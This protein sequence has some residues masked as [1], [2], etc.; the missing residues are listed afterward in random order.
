MKKSYIFLILFSIGFH[1]TSFSQLLIPPPK[2]PS[3][4][5]WA[6]VLEKGYG[7]CEP[8]LDFTESIP[9]KNVRRM[10]ADLILPNGNIVYASSDAI[11]GVGFVV[12][13]Y[14]G[15]TGKLIW[16][17]NVIE[18]NNARFLTYYTGPNTLE[19]KN[20]KILLFGYETVGFSNFKYCKIMIDANTG[21]FEKDSGGSNPFQFSGLGIKTIRLDQNYQLL[22][23][24]DSL[25]LNGKG[26]YVFKFK[27][28]SVSKS[29]ILKTF[30]TPPAPDIS[31]ESG[32]IKQGLK[33]GN[34][35]AFAPE[36]SSFYKLSK[37]AFMVLDKDFN[38]IHSRDMTP[39]I[40]STNI[41]YG[42]VF[43]VHDLIYFQAGGKIVCLNPNLDILWVKDNIEPYFSTIFEYKDKVMMYYFVAGGLSLGRHSFVYLDQNGNHKEVFGF[44]KVFNESFLFQNFRHD[45]EGN[46]FTGGLCY[47]ERNS[48]GLWYRGVEYDFAMKFPASYF[49]VSS[50]S[51]ISDALEVKIFPNPSSGDF[52]IETNG[53]GVLNIQDV[54]GKI[55]K[56]INLTGDGNQEVSAQD[57]SS[58]IYFLQTVSQDGTRSPA[59]KLVKM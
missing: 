58:G 24:E 32:F 16:H 1:C 51:D 27:G 45:T 35:L 11:N 25:D 7:G 37:Y 28:D 14:D 23:Y 20:G 41:G 3:Y 21:S 29:N 18:S 4:A 56:Q 30:R 26:G 33:N 46:L 31:L 2:M 38:I 22:Q 43:V 55:M 6:Q 48:A 59:Q 42:Q 15:S 54:H 34:I 19:Y 57:L 17:A 53:S 50:S 12:S 8:W 36:H 5:I 52:R 47:I 39:F 44:D 10:I 9:I 49:S 40:T 13:C